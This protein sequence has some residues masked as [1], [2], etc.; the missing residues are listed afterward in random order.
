MYFNSEKT[1]IVCYRCAFFH[2]LILLDIYIKRKEKQRDIYYSSYL[3]K[4]L[5]LFIFSFI[6]LYKT[7]DKKRQVAVG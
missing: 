6:I 2:S 3:Y 1:Q 7:K 4:N 5:T